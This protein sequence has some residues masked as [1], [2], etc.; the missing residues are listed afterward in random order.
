LSK[1]DETIECKMREFRFSEDY[2]VVEGWLAA[3]VVVGDRD[4]AG[5][6]DTE[7]DTNCCKQLDLCCD[8]FLVSGREY[9]N[10]REGRAERSRVDS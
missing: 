4:R 3:V 1:K 2:F 7:G 8:H 10:I 9:G 5:L 6:D